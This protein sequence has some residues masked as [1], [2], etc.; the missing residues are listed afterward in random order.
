MHLG[1]H[2]LAEVAPA[3]AVGERYQPRGFLTEKRAQFLWLRSVAISLTARDQAATHES[4]D[5]GWAYWVELFE[6]QELLWYA[7]RLPLRFE[8][9]LVRRLEQC[10]SLD[11]TER[12]SYGMS[13]AQKSAELLHRW[14]LP[15]AFED[16]LRL[17]REDSI[18]RSKAPSPRPCKLPGPG[19]PGCWNSPAWMPGSRP[20]T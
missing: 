20:E 2:R 4:V 14:G 9:R 1:V 19:L 10:A 18:S 8:E 6:G 13:H 15:K 11:Q 7:Q 3:S 17:I 12:E 16:T 5:A